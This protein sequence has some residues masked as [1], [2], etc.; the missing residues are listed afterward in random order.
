MMSRFVV[1]VALLLWTVADTINAE[2]LRGMNHDEQT[3]NLRPCLCSI[4]CQQCKGFDPDMGLCN[5]VCDYAIAP[6]CA[7]L[8]SDYLENGVGIRDDVG[9]GTNPPLPDDSDP[10]EGPPAIPTTP[11]IPTT[12]CPCKDLCKPSCG[13]KPCKTVCEI[14]ALPD[15]E[16]TPKCNAAFHGR[17]P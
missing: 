10:T 13:T 6:N 3:R 1:A 5:D 8:C 11:S 2:L 16:C 9:V 14:A 17:L 12:P 4:L 15:A 7:E